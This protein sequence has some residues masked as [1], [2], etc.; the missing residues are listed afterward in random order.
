[1]PAWDDGWIDRLQVG[2]VLKTPSGDLRVVREV[3]IMDNDRS[4]YHGRVGYLEFAIRHCSWTGRC[5]TCKSRTD[6]KGW[7]PMGYRVKLDKEIDREIEHC[8][9]NYM[10]E[11]QTLHCCDVKGVP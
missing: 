10:P 7:A 3:K 6:L 8:L 5:T 1:M 2:D 4:I 11:H 9:E